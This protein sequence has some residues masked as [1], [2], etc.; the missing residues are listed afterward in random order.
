M[1]E[2]DR[3]NKGRDWF[4]PEKENVHQYKRKS[5]KKEKEKKEGCGDLRGKKTNVSV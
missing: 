5:K 1:T 4:L 2:I 3:Y